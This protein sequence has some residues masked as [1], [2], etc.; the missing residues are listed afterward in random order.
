[1][2]VKEFID[3]MKFTDS[4]ANVYILTGDTTFQYFDEHRYRET[5]RCFGALIDD[6]GDSE[7]NCWHLNINYVSEIVEIVIRIK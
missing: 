2:K 3:K 7:V 5:L 1:M 4:I 6:Y